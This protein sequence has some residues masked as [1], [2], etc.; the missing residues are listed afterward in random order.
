MSTLLIGHILFWLAY[1]A[2]LFVARKQRVFWPLLALALLL[3]FNQIFTPGF[4]DLKILDG[5]LFGSRIDILQHGAKVMLLAL[6]MALVIGTGGVD[7]SVGAVMALAGAVMARLAVVHECSPTVA[8]LG[9]LGIALLAGAWNGLLVAGFGIQPIVATL[10]LMVAGRGIAQLLTDG[11]I[12]NFT[13]ETL[14]F[15]G[16]GHFLGMPFTLTLV[17]VMLGI[18]CLLTRKTALGLFIESVGDN[19]TASRYSGINARLVKFCV[20]VFCGLCAGLAGIVSASN[21]KCADANYAGLY[22]ELDAILAVVV[23]GTAL[24]GGRFYLVGSLVG[25]LL[26]QTLTTTMYANNVSADIAPVPKAIVII[27]VCL[28]QSEKVRRFFAR[29][30]PAKTKSVE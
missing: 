29:L 25:A 4:F 26:I 30:L 5:H 19:D 14:V 13:H 8:I 21:I 22:L 16:N 12:I 2:I 24:T 17:L 10:I 20:Y 23:G 3:L 28:L 15:I 18:T 27:A 7:L 1:I 11:Q 6:G 9:A